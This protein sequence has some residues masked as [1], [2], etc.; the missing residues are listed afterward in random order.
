MDRVSPHARS[1]IMSLVKSQHGRTTERRMRACLAAGGVAGWRMNCPDLTG[2]PD[3]VFRLRRIV[4]FVDG[5]FWH[6][7]ECKRPSKTRKKFWIEKVEANRK[8]DKKV[9]RTLRR[10]GWLVLRIKECELKS[11]ERRRSL[12]EKIRVLT[13]S[14]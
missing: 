2:K 6:G 10:Q 14:K 12:L 8:R 3:F 9:N 5:C 4:I 7:C 11:R 13:F 1:R